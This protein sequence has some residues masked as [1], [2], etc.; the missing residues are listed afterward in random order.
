MQNLWQDLRYGARMLLKK[1]GF[2]LIAVLTLALGIGANTAIFSVVN[3]VLLR[4]LP[5][6]DAERFVVIESGDRTKGEEQMGGIA[7]GN[8]WDMRK[9]IQSFEE[10]V[11]FM[12]SG[13]SFKDK[14]N[15]ETVPGFMVTPSFFQ[16]LRARPLLGRTIEERD[17][18]NGCPGVMVL[19]HRLWMRR[20]GGDTRIIGRTLAESGVQVIGVMPPDFRYPANSE[21]WQP[22]WNELQAQDRASRYFYVYGLLKPGVTFEQARAELRL[23]AARFEK[24]FPKENKNLGFALT[25]FRERLTRDVR[26]SLL[27]LLGAVGFVLLI[28]CANVAN[29]LLAKAVA[30]CKELAIR[31][32]LGA[33]RWR[34]VRQILSESL[35][36]AV[37]SALLG[38][39][40][41]VWARKGLLQILP[42]TYSYLQLEGHLQLDWRVLA[43]TL[44][45]TMVTGLLFGLLPAWQVSLSEAGEFLQDGQRGTEGAHTRRV[46]SLLVVTE[47]SLALVLLV[48]AGLLINSFLRLQRVQLGF[49]PQNVFA[50][51]LSVPGKMAQAEKAQFIRQLQEAVA[52][53]PDVEAAAVTTGFNIFPYLNFQLNRPDKPL[54]ADEPVMYDV[55]SPNY[56]VALRGALVK[57]RYFTAQ[58]T[59]TT[60]PVAIINERLARKY[61][62]DEDPL[63]KTVTLNYIGRLQQRRIVGVV[64]DMSQGEL[65]RLAPQLYV[66]FTQQTWFGASLVVRARTSPT[67]ASRA[68]QQALWAIDP[69]QAVSKLQTA[70]EAL[71]E[72]LDE[73][74]LYTTL[75]GLFAGLALVL[76]MVGIVGVL[77]YNVAQRTHEIGIRMA[78]G[79]QAGDVLRL[80]IGQGMRLALAGVLVGLL[81][82]FALTRVL[83]GLLFG[84]GATDPLTF[85]VIALVLVVVALLASYVP[86]RRAT[87]VDPLAALRTE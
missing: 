23:I 18:C 46:R 34:L 50:V 15:P 67:A 57:G 73:P 9:T 17:T 61:F 60:E 68:A 43:F 65:V 14:E 54:P 51:N 37:V 33:S 1:P 59:D 21:V 27:V 63:E 78:L 84:V 56:F 66:P 39:L 69:K 85:T 76:A 24:E 41:A 87:K 77:S 13:Y 35:L 20:F 71:G 81:A 7:P 40:F 53:V 11:G 62:V 19:S 32:A 52:N 29:L 25:P 12:G 28:V 64:R 44:G 58:D 26:T 75:L 3:A 38:W 16:A 22:L 36:L 4:P 2:T 8:Y 72:K 10:F 42:K 45:V 79:A 49:D 55:I 82:S 47:V 6:L 48:G 70:E 31:A 30:R 5:Y 74:R 80:V 83:K 86:A